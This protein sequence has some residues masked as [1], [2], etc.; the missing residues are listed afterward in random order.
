MPIKNP[1]RFRHLDA[2]E[3]AAC[4]ARGDGNP[5]YLV[6]AGSSS[7]GLVGPRCRVVTV[8]ATA[9]MSAV[10]DAVAQCRRTGWNVCCWPQVISIW[11][12]GLLFLVDSTPA[13]TRFKCFNN[14]N[15]GILVE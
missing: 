12:L 3:A 13:Q 6:P 15:V 1:W 2:A 5:V 14:K 10:P 11:H 8:G 9:V 7:F 4:D